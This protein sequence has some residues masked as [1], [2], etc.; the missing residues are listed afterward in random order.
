MTW[1]ALR[2]NEMQWEWSVKHTFNETFRSDAR[3]FRNMAAATSHFRGTNCLSVHAHKLPLEVSLPKRR[4]VN[5]MRVGS[6]KP[7]LSSAQHQPSTTLHPTK[8]DAGLASSENFICTSWVV[9]YEWPVVAPK[10]RCPDLR[11]LSTL[12]PLYRREKLAPTFSRPGRKTS[13]V[14]WA[15]TVFRAPFQRSRW[16]E[17]CGWTDVL[18]T[19]VCANML[20]QVQ[21]DCCAKRTVMK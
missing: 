13:M 8:R 3:L 14:E 5:E 18:W 17:T 20:F 10:V 1:M 9:H 4:T 12:L 11:S 7:Q 15:P 21:E 6:T 19:Q 16:V 2:C